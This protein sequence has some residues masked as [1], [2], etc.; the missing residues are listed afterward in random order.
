MICLPVESELLVVGF[1]EE[2]PILQAEVVGAE[3]IFA[4]E[5][6]DLRDDASFGEKIKAVGVG[7]VG[8]SEVEAVVARVGRVGNSCVKT[9]LDVTPR[10]RFDLGE[11][12]PGSVAA[13]EWDIG[14]DPLGLGDC[15]VK[16]EFGLWLLREEMVRILPSAGNGDHVFDGQEVS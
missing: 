1:P 12:T 7:R 2:R 14:T 9:A 8:E 4:G 11:S 10:S 6:S 13:V 3:C 15:V 5:P 16:K